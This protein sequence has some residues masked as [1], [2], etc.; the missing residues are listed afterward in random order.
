MCG[1]SGYLN[2]S[3]TDFKIEKSLL[4]KM[5]QALT[6]RGP[7]DR[8]IWL[9]DQDQI[10]FAHNR[11][12]II[13]LSPA[14]HQPMLDK[15]NSVAICFN[16]EIYNHE[17][18]RK[19]LINRGYKY[20]SKTDTETLIY[21]Y[22]EW[23][24]DFLDKI[25]GMFAIAIFDLQKK[26]FY[27]I[28]DRIGIK[29]VYFSFQNGIA[30]FASEIKALWKL[31]WIKRNFNYNAYYHYLTFMVTP[32]PYTIFNGIYKLPAGFYLK[33]DFSKKIDFYQWYSPLKRL[34][35]AQEQ[36]L[37]DE[38]FCL[39][40]TEYLLKES[41]KKRMMSDVPFGAFLSGGVDSSLNVAL[42]SEC[43]RKIKTFTVAFSDGPEF[44]ELKYAR[45]VAKIFDTDHHEI[46]ISEKEAFDFYQKM[47]HHLDEPLADCVCIPFYYV[48]KLAKDSGVTVAQVGEGADE[49]FFGYSTY[50]RYKNFYDKYWKNS[51]KLV[52]SL[53][54]KTLYKTANKLAPKNLN[55]LEVLKN[56]AYNRQL[57]WGGAIAF[58]EHQKAL[59]FD[60]KQETCDDWVVQ[61]ILGKSFDL[62]SFS[63]V[64]YYSRK[65]KKFDKQ[66]D[67][68]KNLTYLE[69]KQRL[70]E[71]LL[72]RADKMSMATG[73]EA[74]VPF[75][76]HK[77][78]EFALN[79][80]SDIKFKNKQ[81]K[82]LLKKISEKYLPKDIIYR[83]KV[84]F[85][86]PTV[87]WYKQGKYFPNYFNKC[88]SNFDM[89][90]NQY[91]TSE[92]TLAVHKWVLQNFYSLK[93]SQ[94]N[95]EE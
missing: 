61:K 81:P 80:P 9:S 3:L 29:P 41:I 1:I 5:Q 65:L 66:A 31:P 49:L 40:K 10:G 63:I 30:S 82:Y 44:N 6:H 2:L 47:I 74:R 73:V 51:Q 19:E 58:S 37:K 28:R 68:M 25:D 72:M 67:F 62:D 71:L 53:I 15:Q 79:V 64:D 94:E 14:G 38:D 92:S 56:W 13:D 12:S 60:I 46:I 26:E 87:R 21:A 95:F 39:E 50:A 90:Q 93:K 7:D 77:L 17:E 75:L 69:L 34:S 11:L 27:L 32:A 18:L 76:D 43:D 4:Y 70:P 55:Q 8:G 52:P 33:I 85:A 91:K 24:I 83:K 23:G 78:V 16:G 42:M 86:A 20:F 57:F 88:V 59:F 22:K 45:Q 54:K 48:A 84:G 36:E 89:I 35:Y